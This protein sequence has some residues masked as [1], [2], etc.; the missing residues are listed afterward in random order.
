ML[1]PVAIAECVEPA[2]RDRLDAVPGTEQGARDRSVRIRVSTEGDRPEDSSLVV[3]D[4]L[5][6]VQRDSQSGPAGADVFY[7]KLGERF[8]IGVERSDKVR[9]AVALGAR[10]IDG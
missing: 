6:R 1:D 5:E 4:P 9:V 8:R 7:S 3:V 10:R 2:L